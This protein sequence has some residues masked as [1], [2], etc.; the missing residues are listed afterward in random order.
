MSKS[1]RILITDDDP[2]M[3]LTM[4]EI[5]SM[6]GFIVS[7]AHGADEGLEMIKQGV[8]C[9]LSDIVMPGRNG[10]EFQQAAIA[11]YGPIPF[12][13]MTAYADP[14]IFAIAR[15]QGAL[16]FFEK[17]VKIQN[18]LISLAE[19]PFGSH[20]PDNNETL[21]WDPGI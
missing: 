3:G 1:L 14:D 2:L 18:L 6:Y 16:A 5:L 12:M 15:R 9:V 8:D 13:F 7:V 10:V 19:I 17:P 20:S 4:A 21:S 11:Q